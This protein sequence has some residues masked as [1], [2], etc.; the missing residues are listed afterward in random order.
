M[1]TLIVWCFLQE[2]DEKDSRKLLEQQLKEANRKAQE[3]R[4]QLLRKEQEAEEYRLKLEAIANGQTNGTSTEPQ[5]E[6]VLQEEEEEV[7]GEEEVVMLPEGAII[8]KEEPLDS[9][10][11]ETVTLVEAADITATSEEGTP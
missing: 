10:A 2:S 3:Y 4:Q 11:G 5:E 7:V 9:T 1:G 8:I 6:V